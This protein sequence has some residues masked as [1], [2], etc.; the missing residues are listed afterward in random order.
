M[1]PRTMPRGKAVRVKKVSGRAKRR[2]AKRGPA[3]LTYKDM[4]KFLQV[5]KKYWTR[6]GGDVKAVNA[7][8]RKLPPGQPLSTDVTRKFGRLVK[9]IEQQLQCP[10][11]GHVQNICV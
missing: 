8:I 1:P 7:M 2:V 9:R 3:K 5:M 10:Y 4:Q 6:L 11:P